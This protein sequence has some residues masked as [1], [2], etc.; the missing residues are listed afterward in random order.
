VRQDTLHLVFL[1]PMQYAGHM[2]HS[3]ASGARNVDAIFFMFGCA[4]CGSQKMCRRTHYTELVFLNLARSMCHVVH[5]GASRAQ[6]SMQYFSS[7]SG[8]YV[9]QLKSVK[10]CYTISH[11]QVGPVQ[12]P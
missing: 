7:P 11:A 8:P 10:C 1:H 9:D 2:V 5:S 6:T 12:I 4:Q 3:G